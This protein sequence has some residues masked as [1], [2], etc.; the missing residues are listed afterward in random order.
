MLGSLPGS[1]VLQSWSHLSAEAV[2]VSSL[3][4][5]QAADRAA[6]TDPSASSQKTASGGFQKRICDRILREVV[7][8]CILRNPI[9]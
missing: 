3:C 6:N 4:Y 2:N 8:C 9:P 1:S 5:R 7:L